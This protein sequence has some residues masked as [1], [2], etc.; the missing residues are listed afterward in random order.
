MYEEIERD[1]PECDYTQMDDDELEQWSNDPQA[2]DEINRREEKRQAQE[3][4]NNSHKYDDL[5]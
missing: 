4:E 1:M 2:R 5:V 3:E